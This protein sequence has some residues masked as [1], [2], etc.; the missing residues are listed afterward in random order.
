MNM[1]FRALAS[2]LVVGILS[3]AALATV[4]AYDSFS[5]GDSYNTTVTWTVYN[6]GGGYQAIATPF[7]STAT[8]Q[9]QT[10]SVA[11]FG[12]K[13]FTLQLFQDDGGM[14]GAVL[15]TMTTSISPYRYPN[16]GLMTI[17]SVG[18]PNL[19]TG[20]TY[21][22]GLLPASNSDGGWMWNNSLRTG[23]AY[24]TGG[25]ASSWLLAGAPNDAQ[26]ALRVEVPEP[27]A[28]GVFAVSILGLLNHRWRKA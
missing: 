26:P 20:N 22:V 8:G 2:A 6:A 15:E 18:Q 11:V 9:V 24:K 19:I 12:N 13:A 3:S 5:P 1:G 28:I 7:V 4:T 21:W 16:S 17:T 14:H 25:A 23:M 27:A 10:Y